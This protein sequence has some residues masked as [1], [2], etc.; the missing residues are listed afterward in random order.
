MANTEPDSV[1]NV[2][3]LFRQTKLPLQEGVATTGIHNPTG[4]NLSFIALME[5]LHRMKVFLRLQRD[6]LHFAAM[7]KGYTLLWQFLT[8]HIL[9][10]TTVDLVGSQGRE[11]R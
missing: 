5:N 10:A 4:M 7:Q 11:N 2:T 1:G 6:L 3:N 9:Q 8:K